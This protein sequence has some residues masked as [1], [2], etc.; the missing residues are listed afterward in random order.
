[1]AWTA[2]SPEYVKSLGLK[3]IA[4]R[5]FS[6]EFASDSNAVLLNKTAVKYMGLKNPVGTI[7]RDDD[8]EA[9]R[10]PR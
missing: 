1:M 9:I 10:H 5:D 8:K 4:G 7:I 6:R 2:V 3:I